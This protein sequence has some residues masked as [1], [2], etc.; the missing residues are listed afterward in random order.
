M[1]NADLIAENEAQTALAH[2]R[3]ELA[4]KVCGCSEML[5]QHNLDKQ[6]HAM[7]ND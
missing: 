7:G 6:S 3:L 1:N 4:L 2:N 5:L